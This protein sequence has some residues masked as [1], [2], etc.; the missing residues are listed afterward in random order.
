MNPRGDAPRAERDGEISCSTCGPTQVLRRP[1]PLRTPSPPEKLAGTS[2]ETRLRMQRLLVCLDASSRASNVLA[3]ALDLASSTN[4][5]LCLLRVVG[6]PVE[7][8]QQVLVRG[9]S[10]V[11][12]MLK[13]QAQRE[14]D[15]YAEAAPGIVDRSVVRVGA[16]W[17]VICRE[18]D[19]VEC[20]LVVIGSHGYSGFDRVLGT[21]AAKVVNHCSR[22][23]L[24]V[25][26]RSAARVPR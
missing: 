3:A 11:L 8:D 10:D 4:A 25:R 23:V 2:I 6:L 9:T 7:I 5:R 20:D 19:A 14:L 16:P 26:P 22:S 18:A 17:D 15:A 24:V 12:A 21:T 1:T 13:E